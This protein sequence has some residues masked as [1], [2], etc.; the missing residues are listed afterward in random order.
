[1]L[2][3]RKV[4]DRQGCPADPPILPNAL[5]LIAVR[6][7]GDDGLDL[8]LLVS[9]RGRWRWVV[10]RERA[11]HVLAQAARL[12]FHLDVGAFMGLHVDD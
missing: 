4:G 7:A 11:S 8:H 9:P 2:R 6:N 12:L 5:V 1:M 10:G 3:C